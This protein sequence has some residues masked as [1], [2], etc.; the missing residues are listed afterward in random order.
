VGVAVLCFSVG[1]KPMNLYRFYTNDIGDEHNHLVAADDAAEAI[2]LFLADYHG[3]VSD[4]VAYHKNVECHTLLVVEE[5]N[6]RHYQ[7][8]WAIEPV[9][10]A[11]GVLL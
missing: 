9:E 1:R 7:A 10:L 2:K 4:E 5:L 8:E 11:K 6:G 3:A